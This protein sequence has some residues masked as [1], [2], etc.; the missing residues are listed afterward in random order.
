M[1][2]SE[3]QQAAPTISIIQRD[4]E[5]DFHHDDNNEDVDAAGHTKSYNSVR[6]KNFTILMAAGVLPCDHLATA[7]THDPSSR[8]HRQGEIAR[9]FNG[10]VDPFRAAGI[11]SALDPVDRTCALIKTISARVPPTRDRRDSEMMKK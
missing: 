3:P 4:R 2:R 8:Y 5:R 11:S 6:F 10:I 9:R 1:L 7:S